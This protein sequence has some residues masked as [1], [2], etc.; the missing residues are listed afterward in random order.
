MRIPVAMFAYFLDS[1]KMDCDA[2]TLQISYGLIKYHPF[3]LTKLFINTQRYQSWVGVSLFLSLIFVY[4]VSAIRLCISLL[5]DFI[6]GHFFISFIHLCEILFSQKSDN[7][8]ILSK[9]FLT[10]Q[11]LTQISIKKVDLLKVP[12][13]ELTLTEISTL[14][15]RHTM[16]LKKFNLISDH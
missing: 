11:F 1:L 14:I 5:I 4:L 9:V 13:I 3:P 15:F 7:F 10:Y 6:S 8:C 16:S 12:Q 2:L